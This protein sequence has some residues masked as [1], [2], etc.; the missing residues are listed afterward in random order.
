MPL[1]ADGAGHNS[2]SKPPSLLLGIK[3][4]KSLGRATENAFGSS[5]SPGAKLLRHPTGAETGRRAAAGAGRPGGRGRGAAGDAGRPETRRRRLP[6]RQASALRPSLRPGGSG[7]PQRRLPQPHQ[8]PPP[9]R[10]RRQAP[11][12]DERRPAPRR[13]RRAGARGGQPGRQ[14]P[15][16]ACRA[17]AGS[18]AA[19]S[20]PPRSER[21]GP[22]A[23][24]PLG[25]PPSFPPLPSP[26]RLPGAAGRRPAAAGR[27]GGAGA[28]GRPPLAGRGGRGSAGARG[29]EGAGRGGG[30]GTHV[31]CT[32]R[33][34]SRISVNLSRRSMGSCS[35]TAGTRKGGGAGREGG[36]E[37]GSQS[38]SRSLA[39]VGEG[40][41]ASS[42][43]LPPRLPSTGRARPPGSPVPH[44]LT[45]QIVLQI[46]HGGG[47]ASAK[48]LLANGGSSLPIWRRRQQHQR[49]D[50]AKT[51]LAADGARSG[52]AAIGCPRR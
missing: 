44:T 11:G 7:P 19:R 13:C 31:L 51:T 5:T 26:S 22:A 2:R 48:G 8:R 9:R 21:S 1:P 25:R 47:R 4:L 28:R 20:C 30:G 6:R 16:P 37:G 35:I 27:G 43:R 46:Q 40:G 42:P 41:A 52:R 38:V 33:S 3:N 39:A 15:G 36:R 29:G 45:L 18:R 12:A 50:S 14:R 49:L 17:A 34:I 32:C 23:A 24:A 10:R